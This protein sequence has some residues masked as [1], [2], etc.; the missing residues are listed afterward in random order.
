[1]NY[2][3]LFYTIHS[4]YGCN[5]TWGFLSSSFKYS[6]GSFLIV[7][8][9]ISLLFFFSFLLFLLLWVSGKF[10]L[11]ALRLLS[12]E[13]L[14]LSEFV[15]VYLPHFNTIYEEDWIALFFGVLSS[16]CSSAGWYGTR[17][18]AWLA[19]HKCHAVPENPY[20]EWAMY[21]HR[22]PFEH[23]YRPWVLYISLYLSWF[24]K[25]KGDNLHQETFVV[26]QKQMSL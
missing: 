15:A 11:A 8:V 4:N 12:S 3:V 22:E 7:C 18:C 10:L 1:M 20:R 24:R 19:L 2:E 9:C 23:A 13:M 16:F 5:F 25:K 26:F 6:Y 21:M 17:T 14:G